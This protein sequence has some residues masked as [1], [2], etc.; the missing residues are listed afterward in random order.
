MRSILT[1]VPTLPAYSTTAIAGAF[2]AVAPKLPMLTDAER[3]LLAE[4]Q[5]RADD[6]PTSPDASGHTD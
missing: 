4:W 1:D 3:V 6:A 2:R 5:D